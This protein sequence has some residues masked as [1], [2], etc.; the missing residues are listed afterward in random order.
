MN[1]LFKQLDAGSPL[2]KWVLWKELKRSIFLRSCQEWKID[3]N[4]HCSADVNVENRKLRVFMQVTASAIRF[5]LSL[6]SSDTTDE[7][8]MML[9]FI[10]KANRH[11]TL[12]SLLENF[13]RLPH[14]AENKSESK[15]RKAESKITQSSFLL[16][17]SHISQ[18]ALFSEKKKFRVWKLVKSFLT[19]GASVCIA[20]PFEGRWWIGFNERFRIPCKSLLRRRMVQ[21][22]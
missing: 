9:N 5:M 15:K 10:L 22:P 19:K 3:S 7:S 13:S 6:R 2:I 21:M 14:P 1:L 20:I 17:E 18:I 12:K 16:L 8:R 11:F 4:L